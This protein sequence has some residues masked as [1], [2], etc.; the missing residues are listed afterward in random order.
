[1]PGPQNRP[2]APT[3][4]CCPPARASWVLGHQ[5]DAP[6]RHFHPQNQD[7]MFNRTAPLPRIGIEEITSRRN[8]L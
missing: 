4:S 1:M 7:K 3:G 6:R 2:N 5:T 8:P